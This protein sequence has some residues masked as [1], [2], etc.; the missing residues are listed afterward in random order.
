MLIDANIS[1]KF[2][3]EVMSVD[4]KN[5]KNSERQWLIASTQFKQHNIEFLAEDIE[6]GPPTVKNESRLVNITIKVDKTVES[7]PVRQELFL[8]KNDS[9]F[10][11]WNYTFRVKNTDDNHEEIAIVQNL[12]QGKIVEKQKWRVIHI[13]EN[14]QMN[15][16]VFSY[17]DRGEHLLGVKLLQRS[18]QPV[19]FKSDILMYYPSIIFPNIYPL[20][21]FILGILIIIVSGIF[22]LINRKF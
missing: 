20:V 8:Y 10:K 9:H 3:I 12:T 18:Q 6:S 17:L 16:E 15:E 22:L 11:Y 21:T 1:S 2:K 14:G 4:M 5:S 7:T 19:G 13:N